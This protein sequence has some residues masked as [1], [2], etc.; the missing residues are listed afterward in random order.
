MPPVTLRQN[1][2]CGHEQEELLATL[3][4]S[5]EKIRACVRV[6]VTNPAARRRLVS[7][8]ALPVAP[9]PVVIHAPGPTKCRAGI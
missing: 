4:I 3:V 6:L 7:V 9:W 8:W 1:G 2:R 5:S